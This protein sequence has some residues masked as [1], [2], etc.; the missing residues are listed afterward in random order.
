MHDWHIQHEGHHF[1]LNAEYDV[2]GVTWNIPP[3]PVGPSRPLFEAIYH[4]GPHGG[5]TIE[6]RCA[7]ATAGIYIEF[8]TDV[9]LRAALEYGLMWF[10]MHPSFWRVFFSLPGINKKEDSA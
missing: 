3:G 5:S 7:L 2:G 10:T 8:A 9:T 1:R 4:A 6:F